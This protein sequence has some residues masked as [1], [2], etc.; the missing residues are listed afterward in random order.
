MGW[1]RAGWFVAD[2]DAPGHGAR[3]CCRAGRAL[4]ATPGLLVITRAP[5]SGRN[6]LLHDLAA[7]FRG[8]P[9]VG[10]GRGR[11]VWFVADRAAHG[12]APDD[13]VARVAR[14]WPP[15]ACW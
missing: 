7:A 12:T 13:V 6:T 9:G 15:R 5:G 10:W 11:V 3:R 2:R 4:L 1:G 14:C 8:V